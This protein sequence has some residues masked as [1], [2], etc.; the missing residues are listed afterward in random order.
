MKL[1]Y[2]LPRNRGSEKKK[3]K[4]HIKTIAAIVVAAVIAVYAPG[5]LVQYGGAVF[6]ST[7]A[8]VTT[9]SAVG[10][11]TVGAMAG[12]AS[13]AIMTGSLEGALQGAMWGAVSAGVAF[14]VSNFAS[15]L[16]KVDLK[17]SIAN[18]V[19]AGMHKAAAIKSI[20]NSLSRGLIAKLQ[21]GSFKRIFAINMGSFAMRALYT[22]VVGYGVTWK[23][24]GDAVNKTMLTSPV[25]GANNFGNAVW[26]PLNERSG[27]EEGA[28]FSRT[29]NKIP[30]MNAVAG[31]HDI[32]QNTWTEVGGSLLRE[33]LNVPGS[34]GRVTITTYFLLFKLFE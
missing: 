11:M 7:V 16:F 27:M 25:E 32:F 19:K 9:L 31:M 12:F 6:G 4:K 1:P 21:G 8:G 30:G 17:Q 10:V 20:A 26:K 23:S 13:G 29:M 14:G 3:I 34:R 22:K 15:K 28:W 5:L 2:T 24:G 33:V 18:L